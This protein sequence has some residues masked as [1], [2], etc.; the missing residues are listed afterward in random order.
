MF[1]EI[2]KSVVAVFGTKCGV[3]VIG[4]LNS[5]I[6]A[7]GLGAEG[8]GQY[9]VAVTIYTTIFQICCM[10]IHSA[11]NYYLSKDRNKLS[12]IWGNSVGICL[13]SGVLCVVASIVAKL[14]DLRKNIDSEFFFI[15]IFIVPF[16]LYYYLQQQILLVIDKIRLM[17]VLDIIISIVP[18]LIYIFLELKHQLTV[19]VVLVTLIVAYIVADFIGCIHFIRMNVKMEISI[20]FYVKC[21]RMGVQAFIACFLSFLVLRIDLY[22]ISCYLGD[23]ETGKYS[24][25]SNLVDILNTF[26]STIVMVVTS[27]VAGIEDTHKRYI[28]VFKILIVELIVVSAIA[29]IGELVCG[30]LIPLLF[31]K[32]YIDSVVIFRILLI[33][34][35]FLGVSGIYSFWFWTKKSYKESIIAYGIALFVDLMLNYFMIKKFGIM[36]VAIA[37]MISYIVTFCILGYL[38]HIDKK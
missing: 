5:V 13:L 8:Q 6:L 25:A 4:F 17:N 20:P 3:L 10:G 18:F 23:I 22:M 34:M 14:F 31:G 37:S 16:Y 29:F 24:I 38:F 15:I 1:K 9:A 11:Q 35:L 30:G 32:Q 12:V 28:I 27:K 7:R 33:G 2:V 21:L 19:K 36:G 26:C